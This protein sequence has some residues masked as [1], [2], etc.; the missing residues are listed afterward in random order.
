MKLKKVSKNIY[1]ITKEITKS[2]NEK[3]AF[4]LFKK[5][6]QEHVPFKE[7][8]FLDPSSDEAENLRK[9]DDHFVFTLKSKKIKRIYTS[10]AT[11]RPLK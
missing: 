8:R 6:L 1:E 11:T 3:E 7:C 5:K 10:A 9:L 2:L 4:E